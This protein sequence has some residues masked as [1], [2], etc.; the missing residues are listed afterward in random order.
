MNSSY[1]LSK[2]LILPGILLGI[3]IHE[4][5]HGYAADRMG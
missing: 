4:F 3:S 5:A 1:I 2:L